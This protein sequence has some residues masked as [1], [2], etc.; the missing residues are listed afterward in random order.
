M[1]A[2]TV[3]E[4][5]GETAF[6][7]DPAGARIAVR[8]AQLAPLGEAALD[9]LWASLLVHAQPGFRWVR[10]PAM[11]EAVRRLHAWARGTLSDEAAL[12]LGERLG[13]RR[14]AELREA[15]ID[16][17]PPPEAWMREVPLA[18]VRV[19]LVATA[20]PVR[21]LASAGGAPDLGRW[22]EAGAREAGAPTR[23]GEA[24]PAQ[25]PLGPGGWLVPEAGPPLFA[26]L[27]E[28]AYERLHAQLFFD[29]VVSDGGGE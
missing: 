9:L 29:G 13:A 27:F 19:G 18:C 12:E 5:M 24:G 1:P 6:D 4:A 26:P 8:A 14:R 20:E 7:L 11:V 17:A 25:H 10:A 21:A 15:G 2:A 28:P 22:E 16:A 3:S 23:A